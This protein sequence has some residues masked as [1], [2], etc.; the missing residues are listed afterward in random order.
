MFGHIGDQET[1]NDEI[2]KRVIISVDEFGLALCVKPITRVAVVYR[3]VKPSIMIYFIEAL[4]E[5]R[6]SSQ[7]LARGTWTA[8]PTPTAIMM[9]EALRAFTVP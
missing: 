7:Y 4:L 2:V 5:C 9:T 3:W 6:Q 8:G 1:V